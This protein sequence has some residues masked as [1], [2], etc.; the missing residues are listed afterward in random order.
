MLGQCPFGRHLALLDCLFAGRR[1]SCGIST[2]AL[3][4][5]SQHNK[6]TYSSLVIFRLEVE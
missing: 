5:G 2:R 6:I 3:P 4:I 1:F